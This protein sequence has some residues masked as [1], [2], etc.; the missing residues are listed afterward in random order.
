MAVR[1][2][3]VHGAQLSGLHLALGSEDVKVSANVAFGNGTAPEGG[4]DCQ[5]ESAAGAG[6]AGRSNTWTA[7]VGRTSSPAGLCAAAG[8]VDQPKHPGKGHHGKHH[9]KKHGRHEKAKKQRPSDPC[10]C[11]LLFPRRI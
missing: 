1:K 10:S 7:N 6:T 8:K 5:D 9:V 11:G 2:N 4:F 3:T